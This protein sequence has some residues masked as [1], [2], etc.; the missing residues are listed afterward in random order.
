MND[1]I[2]EAEQGLEALRVFEEIAKRVGE[3]K[4]KVTIHAGNVTTIVVEQRIDPRSL[5]SSN[6][7][8]I[9]DMA[10]MLGYGSFE[11]PIANGRIAEFET[12]ERKK[13]VA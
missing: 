12:V 4:V 6:R 13:H 2:R 5:T 9:A 10:T 7:R 1:P 8:I 3:G 11:F